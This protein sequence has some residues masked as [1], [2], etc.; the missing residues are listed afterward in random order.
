MGV[1]VMFDDTEN[2]AI[3]YCS[4]T[5]WAFGPIFYEDEHNDAD[6]IAEEFLEYA[7]TK[8]IR[9]R[10]LCDNELSNLHAE[11]LKVRK[12]AQDATYAE[13]GK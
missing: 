9:V 5:M 4:T 10:T 7:H 1:R 13:E 11:F 8:G 2:Y 6:E 3:I 12:E